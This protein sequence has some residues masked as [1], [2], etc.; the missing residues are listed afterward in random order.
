M[1]D[2]THITD[3]FFTVPLD[4]TNPEGEAITVYA[5]EYCADGGEDKPWLLF[6]QGGRG[7][8]G[9]R[10]SRVSGWMAEALKHYRVLMLDQRGTGL[11][12]PRS[13]E[14]RVGKG[15]REQRCG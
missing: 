5:R 8:K 13:E 10:P 3:H 1:Q 6:L 4:Y 11:S 12:T 15:G 2:G 7:G 14:R 9:A